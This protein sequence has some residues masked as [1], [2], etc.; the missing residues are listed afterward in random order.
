[1]RVFPIRRR[2]HSMKKKMSKQTTCNDHW[3][4]NNVWSMV[5]WFFSRLDSPLFSFFLLHACSSSVVVLLLLILFFNNSLSSEVLSRKQKQKEKRVLF[6][7]SKSEWLA[8]KFNQWEL[9]ERERRTNEEE[10]NHVFL[11]DFD[12]HHHHHHY[13]LFASITLLLYS[14]VGRLIDWSMLGEKN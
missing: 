13:F 9:R 12:G 5:V 7:Q 1:M 4:L 14:L 10:W 3:K 8:L 11:I 2:Q 6:S